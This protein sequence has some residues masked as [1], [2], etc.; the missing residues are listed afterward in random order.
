MTKGS[1]LK[2]Q[3]EIRRSPTSEDVLA[4]EESASVHIPID[5]SNKGAI[6]LK[7]MGYTGGPLKV[8]AIAEPIKVFIKNNKLGIGL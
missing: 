3:R 2:R 1:M 6:L 7:K 5:E 8:D 4:V